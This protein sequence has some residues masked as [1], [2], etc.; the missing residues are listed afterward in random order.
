M[1]ATG[2]AVR[3]QNNLCRTLRNYKITG[4]S[5]RWNLYALSCEIRTAAG[6]G[7]LHH[8]LRRNRPRTD[9]TDDRDEPASPGHVHSTEFP[10]SN[11][12]KGR[13][14]TLMCSARRS[15][16]DLIAEHIAITDRA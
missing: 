11:F 9:G 12:S 14:A 16:T 3:E 4:Q 1:P 13:L 8:A 5:Y 6:A 15:R 10:R 2:A 7:V